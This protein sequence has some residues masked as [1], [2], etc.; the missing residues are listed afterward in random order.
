MTIDKV[1]E[2][3]EEFRHLSKGWHFNKGIPTHPENTS[4][5][6]KFLDAAIELGFSWFNAFPGVSGDV[7]VSIY[8][9]GYCFDADFKRIDNIT[10]CGDKYKE[11]GIFLENLEEL[12]YSEDLTFENTINKLKDFADKFL[13]A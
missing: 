9:N 5:A 2:K 12:F 7:L 10:I 4:A 6:L 11:G 1:K 13:T 8:V 3:I